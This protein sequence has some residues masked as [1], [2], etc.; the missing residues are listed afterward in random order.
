MG[1]P[2]GAPPTCDRRRVTRVCGLSAVVYATLNFP[3]GINRMESDG[4]AHARNHQVL[5]S[6]RSRSRLVARLLDWFAK[7]KRPLPW[8]ATRDPYRI[9][10]SEVMLQQTQAAAGVPF[11]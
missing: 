3:T 9:W 2:E 6:Q 1:L 8:R 7:H 10:I 5:A 4:S 11:Y